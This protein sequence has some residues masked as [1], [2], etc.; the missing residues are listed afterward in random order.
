MASASVRCGP[1]RNGP[2]QRAMH[3]RQIAVTRS[4]SPWARA[5]TLWPGKSAFRFIG[6]AERRL[7]KPECISPQ[8]G[9]HGMS[10]GAVCRRTRKACATAGAQV[11]DPLQQPEG[12]DKMIYAAYQAHADALWP[13]RSLARAAAPALL[14][15][16]PGIPPVLGTR[17]RLGAAYEVF[18]LAEVT[19]C[20]P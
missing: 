7:A 4:M 12:G 15:A 16:A 14:D 17:R 6:R 8:M 19:H 2:P 11:A 13:L 3:S 10:P 9:R 18:N 5:H 20:R 1:N